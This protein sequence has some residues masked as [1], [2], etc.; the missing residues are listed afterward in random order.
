MTNE[1]LAAHF[2]GAQSDD[3]NQRLTNQAFHALLGFTDDG[4]L[5]PPPAEPLATIVNV[6]ARGNEADSEHATP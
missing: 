1:P 5:R 4:E 6:V 3:R 2:N